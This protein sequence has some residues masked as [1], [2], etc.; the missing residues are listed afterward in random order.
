M[1]MLKM[2]LNWKV[3]V[4][5]VA[6]GLGLYAVAPGAMADAIPILALAACPLS[7]LLM[8]K[9]MHGKRDANAVAG[10]AEP[11]RENRLARLKAQQAALDE[12]IEALERGDELPSSRR[13]DAN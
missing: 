3:L 11:P 12:E 1:K 9:V 5:L 7:M 2:C 8:M 4:G 13:A 10:R 6:V